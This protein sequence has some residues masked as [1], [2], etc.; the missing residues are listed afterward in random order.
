[1]MLITMVGAFP[2][3]IFVSYVAVVINGSWYLACSLRDPSCRIKMHIYVACRVSISSAG[4]S[5]SAPLQ[6][7]SAILS[8]S[9]DGHSPFLIESDGDAAT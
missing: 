1:M 5:V 8:I 4:E 9:S 7:I 3:S 2:Q 6:K